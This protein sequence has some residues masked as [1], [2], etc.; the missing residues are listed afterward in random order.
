MRKKR[1]YSSSHLEAKRVAVDFDRPFKNEHK[2]F[3]KLLKALCKD[4]QTPFAAGVLLMLQNNCSI[5]DLLQLSVSPHDYTDA[6]HYYYD[7]QI[8]GLI[9]K[10]PFKGFSSLSLKAGVRAFIDAEVDCANTNARLNSRCTGLNPLSDSVIHLAKIIIADMLGDAPSVSDLSFK[11]G[12]GSNVNVK[13]NTSAYDKLNSTLDVTAEASSVANEFIA[14]C[15]GWYKMHFN[16]PYED[17]VYKALSIVPGDRLSF[18]PKT[19]KTDR[20]I[21]VGATLNVL[22]Q[23]GIG[24]ELRSRLKP[25]VNLKTAQIAHKRLAKE[26]SLTGK[27]AT[28]DLSSASDTISYSIVEM[29]F[30]SDWFDLLVAVRSPGYEVSSKYDTRLSK[31]EYSYYSY[32]KFSAMGNGYTF[33][34]ES[35]LFYALSKASAILTCPR[36]LANGISVYGDDIIC[37]TDCVDVLYDTLSYCGFTVNT[38]KSFTYGP[39]RESCGGDYFKGIDVRP[40]YLKG[41]ISYRTLFL[42]NNFIERRELGWQLPRFR[43]TIRKLIGRS[44]LAVF[45]GTGIEGDNHIESSLSRQ[46]P[47]WM[48]APINRLKKVK[49]SWNQVHSSYYMYKTMF[50]SD[51]TDSL[52]FNKLR[53][54]SRWSYSRKLHGS[55]CISNIPD[56]LPIG[57]SS[58]VRYKCESTTSLVLLSGLPRGSAINS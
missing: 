51:D 17:K 13:K 23:K 9:K 44:T 25:F 40:F 16:I 47:K 22:I 50:L 20:P 19:A 37:P 55:V 29:L 54:Y 7:A 57:S 35:I 3:L 33:E 52:P 11:F 6:W 46:L 49:T 48:L 42:M 39:F 43:S 28:V 1:Y 32:N 45:T 30:P 38:E 58:N 34:L 53:N 14:T 10:K 15:P 26:N 21:A 27:Y 8:V 56:G 36:H 18:V 12:P 5:E 4:V 2:V 41:N 24:K 31:G